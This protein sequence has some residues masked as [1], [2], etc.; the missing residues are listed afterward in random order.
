MFLKIHYIF[1]YFP[2]YCHHESQKIYSSPYVRSSYHFSDIDDWN[3]NSFFRFPGDYSNCYRLDGGADYLMGELELSDSFFRCHDRI[4]SICMSCS[5]R[6]ECDDTRRWF[7]CPSRPT[8]FY[9]LST[10]GYVRSV[11]WKCSRVFYGKNLRQRSPEKI[12]TLGW[13]RPERAYFS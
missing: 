5:T 1:P 6:D 10:S 11:S 12:W 2:L 9:A 4:I 13:P 8:S 3:W 7:L